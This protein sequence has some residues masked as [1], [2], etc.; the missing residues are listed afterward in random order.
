MSRKSIDE[1]LEEARA[2]LERLEPEEA[3]AAQS[4][5]ALL[6]DT[7]SGDERARLGVIPGSL[8]V[9]LSVLE[10]RLDPDSD[11]EYR[12]PHVTGLDQWIV[13]VCAHGCSTSLAAARLRD[14]GFARATDL[15]GGFEAWKELGLP[16]S[17]SPEPDGAAVPG[18]G[19]PDL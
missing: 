16:V 14:L 2:R 3:L 15:V 5:G 4:A 12:N 6:I 8:H 9:P 1:L 19:G 11:P 13:L 7:R 18:M 17:P 10:W